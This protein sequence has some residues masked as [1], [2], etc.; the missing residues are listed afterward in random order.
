MG[1]G[2]IKTLIYYMCYVWASV[3]IKQNVA[4]STLITV[5][6]TCVCVCLFVLKGGE[7]YPAVGGP[8]NNV[9]GPN[10][11]KFWGEEIKCKKTYEL[12]RVK[13]DFV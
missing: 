8:L 12:F 13:P 10:I 9:C 5:I 3:F 6:I 1:A 2:Y 11:G 7:V 4:E